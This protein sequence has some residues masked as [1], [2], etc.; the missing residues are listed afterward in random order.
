M[1]KTYGNSFATIMSKVEEVLAL[2]KIYIQKANGSLQ[3]LSSVLR[4]KV[5][6]LIENYNDIRRGCVPHMKDN[7]PLRLV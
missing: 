6:H 2:S 5:T 1:E 4:S 7:E 3:T